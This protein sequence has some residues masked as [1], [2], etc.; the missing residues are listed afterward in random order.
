MFAKALLGFGG[1]LL[2]MLSGL[3]KSLVLA[4]FIHY[5]WPYFIPPL[6]PQFVA[7]GYA[8]AQI[9]FIS[10]F[11]AFEIIGIFISLIKGS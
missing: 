6:Y 11:A 10:A 3:A 2:F 1:F 7:A 8:P 4:T 5:L 9:S